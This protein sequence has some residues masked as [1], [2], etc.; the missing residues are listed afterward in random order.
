LTQ[1]LSS[2]DIAGIRVPGIRLSDRLLQRVRRVVAARPYLTGSVVV[3]ALLA[4]ALLNI[5]GLGTHQDA[6]VAAAEARKAAQRVQATQARDL[7]HRVDRLQAIRDELDPGA[8]P[9]PPGT[10]DASP[11][12]LAARAQALADAIDAADREQ[13][14]QDLSRLLQI[15]LDEARRKVDADDAAHRLPPPP[16]TAEQKI[17]RLERHARDLAEGRRARLDAQREG[18]RVTRAHPQARRLYA[19]DAPLAPTASASG[20][21]GQVR[22][23][24]GI[25]R[26]MAEQFKS[27]VRLGGPQGRVGVVGT[28]AGKSVNREHVKGLAG[29]RNATEDD[30]GRDSEVAAKGRHVVL[31]GQRDKSGQGGGIADHGSGSTKQGSTAS[32]NDDA[33]ARGLAAVRIPGS[34]LD[35]TGHAEDAQH[36]FVRYASPPAVDLAT[37][38]T[39]AGRVFGAGGTYAE[40]VYLDTW[41]LIGPFAGKGAE[42]QQAAYPPEDDVDLDAAYA[43]PEGRTLTWQFT[44]R[45]FYPFVPPERRMD[46]VY[47]AYTQIRIDEDRDVWFAFAADDDSQ[48]WLDERLV[49]VSSPGDKPWYHPPYYAR[50]ELVGSLSLTEGQRRVHL[51]AGVHRLLFKLCNADGHPFFSV[52]LS[53]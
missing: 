23:A 11:D 6:R 36:T 32:A 25:P 39:A 53:R 7:Q 18:L 28:E 26:D 4:I 3:H 51:T 22:A 42:S 34:S 45:G 40:R 15:P 43:G 27:M 30:F 29:G 2:P 24:D 46:A 49:W 10:A 5:A 41:Y 33:N 48:M 12:A 52:V 8:K 1:P 20:S 19:P 9:L 35:L 31:E 17:A 44:S 37:L 13:R 14:A 21:T 50:D 38:H 47:Y 16:E